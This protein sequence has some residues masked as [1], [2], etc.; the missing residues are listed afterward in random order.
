[1]TEVDQMSVEALKLE[2]MRKLEQ[3]SA[4]ELKELVQAA[5]DLAERKKGQEKKNLRAEILNKIEAAGYTVD[6][7]FPG[8]GLAKATSAKEKAPAK[9]RNPENHSQTWTGRGRKPRWLVEAEAAGRDINDFAI[10]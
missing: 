2:Q 7:I 3:M 4:S 8:V 6:D 10:G 5:T 1:M 9:Y